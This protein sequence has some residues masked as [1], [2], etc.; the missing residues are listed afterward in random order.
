MTNNGYESYAAKK[1]NLEQMLG[2]LKALKET[3]NLDIDISKYVEELTMIERNIQ[4]LENKG[5][6]V[7]YQI[8]S[9]R[10]GYIETDV[11]NN[12]NLLY[13]INLFSNRINELLTNVDENNID[14]VEE[15]TKKMLSYMTTYCASGRQD[16][17]ILNKA[18]KTVYD[19]LL[20][21]SIFGNYSVF[22][23]LSKLSNSTIKEYLGL[24]ISNDLNK[25]AKEEKS[26]IELSHIKDG[27]G[28]DYLS[29]DVIQKIA[30]V[31]LEKKNEEYL[32]RKKTAMSIIMEKADE[33][34]REK[35][36]IDDNRYEKSKEIRKKRVQIALLRLKFISVALIPI[37]IVGA[38]VFG[39][40]RLTRK[41]K[42]NTRA[43]NAITKEIVSEGEPVY[44]KKL[45]E[46]QSEIT[47]YSP[48]RENLTGDG[49][50]RDAVKVSYSS[51]KI[52]ENINFDEVLKSIKERVQ[53]IETKETLNEGDSLTEPE[54]IINETVLDENNYKQ[55]VGGMIVAGIGM[56]LILILIDMGISGSNDDYE[57]LT[58]LE[59]ILDDISDKKDTLKELKKYRITRKVFRKKMVQIGDKIVKLEEEIG[60]VSDKYNYGTAEITP[61][62][63]EEVKRYIKK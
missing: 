49:Y 53:F 41:F 60:C 24:L 48:W 2:R 4:E 44:A 47:K 13:V 61:E 37:M 28:C 10:L 35:D 7:P 63:L 45:S 3:D 25:L 8:F 57:L 56:A 51:D 29:Y 34:N 55:S 36:E 15:E 21:E 9:D 26:N 52:D 40:G 59:N 32:D 54:I 39:T 27:L 5:E 19:V 14:N 12:F 38:S 18:Y 23:H 1:M 11:E 22:R 30:S 43:Y 17:V 62:S 42:T 46:Y 50:I 20:N 16:E 58:A 31:V 6:E 33:L